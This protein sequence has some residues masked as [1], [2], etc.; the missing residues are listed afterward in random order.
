MSKHVWGNACWYLFHTLAEKLKPDCD[1]EIQTILFHFKQVCFNLPCPSC[2]QHATETLQNAKLNNIKTR[3]DLKHFFLEFHN[4]V[5]KRLNKPIFTKNECD[6]LYKK[7]NTVNIVNH[8][9]AVM[10]SNQIATERTMMN[11]MT[12]HLCVDGVAKYMKQN[13]YKYNA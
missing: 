7:A 13:G 5:N 6:E 12:R 11:T 10:K 9:T 4:L 1:E 3:D 8:F 2:T